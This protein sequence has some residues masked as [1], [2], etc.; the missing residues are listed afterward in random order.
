[1]NS[2]G[3]TQHVTEPSDLKRTDST[4]YRT[5]KET[6]HNRGGTPAVNQPTALANQN[7]AINIPRSGKRMA[8]DAERKIRGSF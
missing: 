8:T 2:K 1:M 7:V 6:G 3:L 5:N 4:R